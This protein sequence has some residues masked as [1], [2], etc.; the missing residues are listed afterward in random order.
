MQAFANQ[1]GVHVST[2]HR[3]K[4]F[5]IMPSRRVAKAI[6]RETNGQVTI[7]DLVQIKGE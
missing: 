2:I 7:S 5:K 4:Y 6:H 3:L 1:V